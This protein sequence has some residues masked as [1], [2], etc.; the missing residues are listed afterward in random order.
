MPWRASSARTVRVATLTRRSQSVTAASATLIAT[1][2][3]MIDT[4]RATR[5]KRA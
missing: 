2:P 3:A 4:R 1:T 5:L